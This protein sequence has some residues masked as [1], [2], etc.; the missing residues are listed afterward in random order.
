M[1]HVSGRHSM[2]CFLSNTELLV[3]ESKPEKPKIFL[4]LLK[5][6][7]LSEIFHGNSWALCTKSSES[8]ATAQAQRAGEPLGSGQGLGL[9]T[10]GPFFQV[11]TSFLP[12]SHLHHNTD[13]DLSTLWSHGTIF[14]TS[15]PFPRCKECLGQNVCVWQSSAPRELF[16]AICLEQGNI[17]LTKGDNS[18]FIQKE[19][20]DSEQF[21]LKLFHWTYFSFS[22]KGIGKRAVCHID[23]SRD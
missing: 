14:V 8:G 15:S 21:L 16:Q 11:H 1:L 17:C 9:L 2:G 4:F 10:L 18:A 3:F 5:L 20:E 13:K 6:C 22:T 12:L 19:N 7:F 23:S